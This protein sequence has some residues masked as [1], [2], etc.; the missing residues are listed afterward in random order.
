[1]TAGSTIS[2]LATSSRLIYWT[3]GLSA[4]QPRVMALAV[5]PY[6]SGVPHRIRYFEAVY[7]YMRRKPGVWF[8]TG[9]MYSVVESLG[10]PG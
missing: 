8:T 6:I 2:R 1:M 4:R 10:T 9:G 3:G 7:D 5:H